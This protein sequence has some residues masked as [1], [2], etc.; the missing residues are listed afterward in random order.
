MSTKYKHGHEVP[1][2]VLAKRLNELSDAVGKQGEERDRELTRR[3]PAEFDRDA[4][5]VLSEAATRLMAL[6]A[7]VVE[8]RDALEDLV[9]INEEDEDN[10]R[11]ARAALEKEPTT[12]L[13]HLKARWQ[14]EVLYEFTHGS[15]VMPATLN[16]AMCKRADELRRQAEENSQ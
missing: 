5:L 2:A 7:H 13:A 12:S 4:D 8:L 16:L 1:T 10:V 3:I 15:Y 11:L 14:A 9:I 6:A